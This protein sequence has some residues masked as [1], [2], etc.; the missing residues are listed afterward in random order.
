MLHVPCGGRNP[1]VRVAYISACISLHDVK[2][3]M[4]S[5]LALLR[6]YILPS[7][8]IRRRCKQLE[9]L[10]F[11]LAV[12]RNACNTNHVRAHSFLLCKTHIS[13]CRT[14]RYA[15]LKSA[16]QRRCIITSWETTPRSF[17]THS[18]AVAETPQ[19]LTKLMWRENCK[20]ERYNPVPN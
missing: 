14:W 4:E 1:R 5:S 16:R 18:V 20:M 6:D 2:T 12:L 17:S 10:W 11:Q 9:L 15:K 19:Y 7:Y 8:S 13:T 3:F